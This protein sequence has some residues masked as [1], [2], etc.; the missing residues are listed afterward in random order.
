MHHILYMM[1]QKEEK[2]L[3]GRLQK[4]KETLEV[5]DH[6]IHQTFATDVIGVSFGAQ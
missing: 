2:S 1:V 3:E 5:A 4:E 6:Q